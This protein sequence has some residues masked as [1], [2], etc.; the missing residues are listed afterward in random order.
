MRIIGVGFYSFLI[1]VIA[2]MGLLS[3]E[4]DDSEPTDENSSI[5]R[6]YISTAEYQINTTLQRY[7]NLFILDGVDQPDFG[8]AEYMAGYA[9]GI[10]G[11]AG[12][13]FDPELRHILQAS[14]NEGAYTD[15]SVQVLNVNPLTGLPGE[16]GFVRS[17]LLTAVKGMTYH[18]ATRFLFLTNLAATS[19]LYAYE[20]PESRNN[21]VK[22]NISMAFPADVEPSGVFIRNVSLELNNE[23]NV[24]YVSTLGQDGRILGYNELP[25]RFLVNREDSIRNNITPDFT[26]TVPGTENLNAMAY[27]PTLDLMVAV[28]FS[29]AN[30]GQILFFEAFSTKTTTGQLRPDRVISGANTLLENPISIAIDTRE[31]ASYLYVADRGEKAVLRFQIT[32]EGNVAPNAELRI[33]NRTPMGISLDA[34]GVVGAD[35]LVPEDEEG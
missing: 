30:V 5:S 15:T 28:D 25:N 35:P 1:G 20:R 11:G 2:F 32:D 19:H 26:L 4:R 24:T 22:P 33:P 6:L 29:S 23:R 18:G 7:N 14:V 12:V 9:S 34:R 13:L 16:R 27:S 21:P 8:N 31:G 17:D 10:K 3:C